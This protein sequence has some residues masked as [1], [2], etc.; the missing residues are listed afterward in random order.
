MIE[1]LK[2]KARGC[3]ECYDA[4]CE[5]S[6]EKS[7]AI[8]LVSYLK[9]FVMEPEDIMASQHCGG[10]TLAVTL[11]SRREYCTSNTNLR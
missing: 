10:I 4:S 1:Y 11:V 6:I 9:R 7:F 2:A 8:I 5:F 3:N